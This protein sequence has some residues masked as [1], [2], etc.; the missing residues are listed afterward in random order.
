V[1]DTPATRLL[2][3]PELHL[4]ARRLLLIA[5]GL[6]GLFAVL[7]GGAAIWLV[8]ADLRPLVERHAGTALE[9]QTSV[10]SLSIDWRNPLVLELRDVRV[11]NMP[12]GSEPDM[13]RFARVLAG[14]DVRALL[15]GVMRFERLVLDQPMILLERHE[16]GERNW[17]FPGGGGPPPN[18]GLAVVPKNRTQFPTLI[19]MSVSGGVLIY[20]SEGRKD[21]RLD[22]RTLAVRSAGDET[23][24]SLTV[25]GAYNGAAVRINGTTDSF[26]RMRNAALPFGTEFT[27]ETDA[28]RLAFKGTMAEPTDFEGVDGQLQITTVTLG[29]MLA[30]FGL[31]QPA[32]FPLRATA[33]LR[34]Q[35]DHWEL[36]ETRGQL[37]ADPFTGRIALTEG[38]RGKPDAL[39]ASVDFPRLDLAPLLG[40]SAGKSG[41][42]SA[43]EAIE[44][45]PDDKPGAVLDVHLRA[46][47]LIYDNLR[48]AE[49]NADLRT[50]PGE[51]ELRKLAFGAAKGTLD[52]SAIMRAVPAGGHLVARGRF[53]GAELGA[54]LGLLGIDDVPLAGRS[55]TLFA[56]DLTGK[57]VKEALAKASR[58]EL[59]V[60]MKEGEVARSLVEKASV[61]LKALLRQSDQWLPVSCMVGVIDMRNGFI[62][63][64]PLRLRT[65]RTTLVA[66][67]LIDLPTERLN[68]VLRAESDA[69][70]FLALKLPIRI[71]GDLAKPGIA[72]AGG[73]TVAWLDEQRPADP[74][75]WMT[76]E[77]HALAVGN[78]CWR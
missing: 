67:G 46:R 65:G 17:R 24:V 63:L 5:A 9:R 70:N 62:K 14:I 69:A 20:R 76:P 27:I 41:G 61:D 37:A 10:G 47:Q 73:P 6:F 25:E 74:A 56:L 72:P 38:E 45:R 64:S 40:S 54:A 15:R 32:A 34:K 11:A 35:G 36:T 39:A 50:A 43:F 59:V 57:T 2:A 77:L 49:F 51:I 19:D 75:Q 30:L 33:H 31:D 29:K 7:A 52:A 18:G 60:A 58:G 12:G 13:M 66:A 78:P 44:L 21:I 53:W 28:G 26:A 68:M 16:N 48:L 1:T 23:P 71:S 22:F 8:T 3:N 55:D 4:I 42:D